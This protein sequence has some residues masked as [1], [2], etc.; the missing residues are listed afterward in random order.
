MFDELLNLSLSFNDENLKLFVSEILKDNRMCLLYWP[1]AF[2][3]HHAIRGGLLYHTLSIVRLAQSVCKIYPSVNADLLIG[4]AM[5]HDIAKTDDT[6]S[7]FFVTECIRVKF[8]FIF[9]FLRFCH[10]YDCFFA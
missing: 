10:Y 1:A 5:L 8:I 3:L 7:Y 2:K 6:H 4:G 9:T